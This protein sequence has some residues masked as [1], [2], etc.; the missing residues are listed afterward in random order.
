LLGRHIGDGAERGA[1]ARQVLFVD[2]CER[3]VFFTA[4]RL[5]RNLGEAEIENLGVSALGHKNV[6]GLDVAVDDV[7]RMRCIERVGNLNTEG[8]KLIGFERMATD[9]MFERQTRPSCSPMS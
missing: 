4:A 6:S 1:R 2:R 7:F 8:Q 5:C 3:D 9:E